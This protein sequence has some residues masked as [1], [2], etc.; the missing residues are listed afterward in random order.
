MLRKKALCGIDNP[1]QLEL[2]IIKKT[3]HGEYLEEILH[4]F[5]S[6]KKNYRNKVEEAI[7]FTVLFAREEKD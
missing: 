5:N 7:V 4:E 3:W 1:S 6:S 2:P